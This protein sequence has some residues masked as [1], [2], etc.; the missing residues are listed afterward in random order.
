MWCWAVPCVACIEAQSTALLA[1]VK[2][3]SLG[4]T[5]FKPSAATVYRKG[6]DARALVKRW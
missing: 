3:V 5:E 1:E 6:R 4:V 2:L